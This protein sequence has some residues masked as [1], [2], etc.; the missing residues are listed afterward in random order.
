MIRVLIADNQ[1]LILRGLAYVLAGHQE[2]IATDEASCLDQAVSILKD[3]PVDVCLV[4]IVF[5]G[6]NTLE[7]IKLLKRISPRT[8][9]VLLCNEEAI[10]T[11]N[12]LIK[13]GVSVF[14]SKKCEISEVVL[15]VFNA[16]RSIQYISPPLA[17]KEIFR[18][19]DDLDADAENILKTL[20]KRE[21]Q[22]FTEIVAGRTTQQISKA[23]FLSPKTISTYR[24]RLLEKL[25][26]NHDV[27]LIYFAIKYRLTNEN[28]H[29]NQIYV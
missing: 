8:K 16:Y 17:Q 22:I 5:D 10:V 7:L 20:S 11:I 24:T 18:R 26:L 1:A 4:D 14:L 13:Q 3:R 2:I 23:L 21:I 12:L 9:I 29:G 15:A 6:H 25:G 27:D 28:I 19:N